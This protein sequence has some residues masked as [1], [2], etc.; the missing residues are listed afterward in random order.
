MSPQFFAT[1]STS[2]MNMPSVLLSQLMPTL[3]LTSSSKKTFG[4]AANR[5]PQD[6]V[7]QQSISTF[8]RCRTLVSCGHPDVVDHHLEV[9]L[10]ALF[11]GFL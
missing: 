3:A 9:V 7:T 1:Q 4:V 2:S 6:S 8:V 11:Q 5:Q 10:N